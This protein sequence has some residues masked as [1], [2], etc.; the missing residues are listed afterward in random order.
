MAT[1]SNNDIARAIYISTKDKNPSEQ[2]QLFS[3]IIKFLHRK[4]LLSQAPDI[5]SRLDIIINKEEGRITV[6][7]SSKEPLHENIKKKLYKF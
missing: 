4:R 3:K 7:I 6:T 5:L 2:S 1:L